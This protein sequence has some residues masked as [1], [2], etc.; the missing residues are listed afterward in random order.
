MVAGPSTD[1]TWGSGA[2]RSQ[3]GG[4]YKRNSKTDPSFGRV[5][6][7]C[8]ILSTKIVI[9]P[10]TYLTSRTIKDNTI[11]KARKVWTARKR[12]NAMIPSR[13]SGIAIM[14]IIEHQRRCATHATEYTLV[15]SGVDLYSL[16]SHVESRLG[17]PTMSDTDKNS[18]EG[19]GPCIAGTNQV[20]SAL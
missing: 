9:C 7:S 10:W 13:W 20:Q 19:A 15:L 2:E 14:D 11:T 18:M 6:S 3:V 12:K 4:K 16:D 5:H 8:R 17:S 1:A